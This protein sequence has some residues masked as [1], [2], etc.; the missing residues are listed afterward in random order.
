ML[1]HVSLQGSNPTSKKEFENL[2]KPI[3]IARNIDRQEEL[4][5]TPK[6]YQSFLNKG[7][8][9]NVCLANNPK[10]LQQTLNPEKNHQCISQAVNGRK[11]KNRQTKNKYY[12]NQV[13]LEEIKKVVAEAIKLEKKRPNQVTLV[14]FARNQS[15][16]RKIV[17]DTK[18][19]LQKKR[20]ESKQQ[21]LRTEYID[22]A[23]QS[24][25]KTR[26]VVITLRQELWF[27]T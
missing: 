10:T 26:K 18:P 13:S 23:P 24:F 12:R 15:I 5:Q 11:S 19:G 20:K 7:A 22:L 17:K 8:G 27:L 1:C 6:F 21:N 4:A 16:S 9:K 3:S 2:E 25:V 14:S